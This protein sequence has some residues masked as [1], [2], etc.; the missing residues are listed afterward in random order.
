MSSSTQVLSTHSPSKQKN[1]QQTSPSSP[2]SK[3]PSV[4]PPSP[5]PVD[6]PALLASVVEVV[7]EVELVTCVAVAVALVELLAAS[8]LDVFEP[9][10]GDVVDAAVTAVSCVEALVSVLLAL[11]PDAVADPVSELAVV[12]PP[13]PTGPT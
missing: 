3:P 1:P 4:N 8:V 2:Q 12:P 10:S 9:P 13:P 7:L 6:P 11:V 5:D